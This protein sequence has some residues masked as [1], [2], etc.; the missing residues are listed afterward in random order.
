M[1]G[2]L[3]R[4][5]LARLFL[6]TASECA[7][8]GW[9]RAMGRPSGPDLPRSELRRTGRRRPASRDRPAR[10]CQPSLA[11]YEALAPQLATREPGLPQDLRARLGRDRLSKPLFCTDRLCRHIEGAYREMHVIF[12]R[13][14]APRPFARRPDALIL[15][16]VKTAYSPDWARIGWEGNMSPRSSFAGRIRKITGA[17]IFYTVLRNCDDYR[18]FKLPY[19][20]LPGLRCVVRCRWNNK[21]PCRP[22]R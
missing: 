15:S 9:W 3:A 2:H 14:D 16:I 11:G 22:G 1:A 4:H 10:T 17:A 6:D 13:G 20:H 19:I 8:H 12:A 18:W 21:N 7:C 5:R